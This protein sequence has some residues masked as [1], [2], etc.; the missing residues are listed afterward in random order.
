[1]SLL[2][3]GMEMPHSCLD[4][5]F[6]SCGSINEWEVVC[7]ITGYRVGFWNDKKWDN[8]WRSSRC[9]LVEVPTPHGRLIDA[10]NLVS[11]IDDE[12]TEQTRTL[13]NPIKVLNKALLCGF[14]KDVITTAPTIIEAEE[15]AGR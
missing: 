3:K 1:M 2:I 9:P 11:V 14:A 6:H 13:S 7:D 4:C 8:G 5:K 12:F 15:G 10:D